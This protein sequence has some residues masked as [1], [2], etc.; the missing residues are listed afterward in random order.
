[1][2]D[3]VNVVSTVVANGF[4]IG[5]GVCAGVCPANALRMGWRENG[6]LAADT[7]SCCLDGCRLCLDVCPF[8]DQ[9]AD[10]T[11]LA[12]KRFACVQ[13]MR[14]E[15]PL[16]YLLATY[17]GYS[18]TSDH[19][20]RG[21]SGGMCTWV[22]EKLLEGGDVDAVVCVGPTLDPNWL[23]RFQCMETI[24]AVRKAGGSRYYPVHLEDVVRQLCSSGDR[25]K[26][27]VVGLPCA[28]KGLELVMTQRP[29]VRD[30]AAFLLGLACGHLPNRY[31]T[32]Y[33]G[34][35]SGIAPADLSSAEYRLKGK[36]PASNFR[37]QAVA[38]N[39]ILGRLVPFFGPPSRGWGTGHFQFEA[40]NYCDDVFAEL[41]DASFMDA[42]LPVYE[43]D[44]AGHS[45]VIAR[46]PR[47]KAL[48][49]QGN[50]EGT[51][52]LHPI[53]LDDVIASQSGS[54]VAKRETIAGWL[55]AAQH[56][57]TWFPTKRI[58]PSKTVWEHHRREIET[59]DAV[60]RESKRTW[61]RLRESP[62]W[63]FRLAMWG[64]YWPLSAHQF[65]QRI[66][67]RLLSVCARL[68]SLWDNV[69]RP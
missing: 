55:H 26:Y 53:S 43:R 67:R 46:H 50:Q 21:A 36:P 44:P 35:L 14:H 18:L 2:D 52:Q 58:A 51:C 24:D 1:M 25:R 31:Y 7:V 66:Q 6:D 23:F 29:E 64:V 61:R 17:V 3:P 32:E 8:G 12:A 56:R 4:C 54:I 40:C 33:L 28:L 59:R 41:G 37:F 27:V 65:T 62:L 38:R 68:H 42:W 19:R 22:L 47:L 16:G 49:D 9:T 30:R 57:K 34:R 45:I 13:G 60:Q 10:E 39:G 5:C 48:L 20:S 15:E 11:F 63:R 69:E